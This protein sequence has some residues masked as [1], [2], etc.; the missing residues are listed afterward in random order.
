MQSRKILRTLFEMLKTNQEGWHAVS[1]ENWNDSGREEDHVVGIKLH[2]NKILEEKEVGIEELEKNQN[3]YQNQASRLRL[4]EARSSS[5]I[6]GEKEP[7][8][9]N[10]LN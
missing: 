1:L 3:Q 9:L 7:R 4:F 8:E 5:G 10:R 2:R 6:W